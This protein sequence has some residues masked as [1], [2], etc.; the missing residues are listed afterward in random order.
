[1]KFSKSFIFT[2]KE[3]PKDAE[4][5][6]HKLMYRSSMIRKLASGIYEWLPIGLKVLRKVENIIRRE[7]NNAGA[8]E[9]FLPALQPKELWEKSSRWDMYGKE[10]M[11]LKDRHD[12]MFCLGPTHEE[13]ITNQVAR[14]VKS[15]RDLPVNL[16]QFQTK[17][18]DEI[19]PRFGIMRAREF[20]MKDAYSFDIDDKASEQSYK[21]M[22]ETY[23][24]IFESCG[25][26]FKVVEADSGMIGGSFSHEFM[27]LADTGESKIC[28]CDCGYSANLEK[29]SSNIPYSLDKNETQKNI[30]KIKTPNLKTVDEVSEFIKIPK[31]KFIKS[32]VYKVNDKFIMVLVRGDREVN[33]YK[34]S[35]YLK[36]PNINLAKEEEILKEFSSPVGFLGPVN[37]KDVRIIL[38]KSVKNIMNAVTG[39]NELDCHYMNVNINRDFNCDEEADISNVEENDICIHCGKKLQFTYGIEVGHVFKLGT[40]YSEPM[41]AFYIDEKGI[42]KPIIMGCYGIGVSRVVAAAIEQ[43]NDK[44]GIIWPWALAP[45]HIAVVPLDVSNELIKK[46]AENIYNNLSK[47]GYDVIIDDRDERP[48]VK[49]KDMDLIGIPIRVTIG[50]KFLE[51]GNIEIKIRKTQE[52]S[53]IKE[54]EVETFIEECKTKL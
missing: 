26:N 9:V 28:Y 27:V 22:Y 53:F 42:K 49:F 12:H 48:G 39:A 45:Y 14:D 13:I 1:M 40:K 10:L 34:L 25:L 30:E 38:D 43:S 5:I 35:S 11:R 18:R 7:M 46:T 24:K 2:L 8:L 51:N 17:F 32:L 20:L 52:V 23:K 21:T 16:Y 31:E 4:I 19:R 33:E 36:T 44:D 29:A 6:S 54:N 37:L 41:G 50:K 3:D 47:K 15:Y